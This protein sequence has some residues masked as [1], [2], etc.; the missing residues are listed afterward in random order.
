MIWYLR[1]EDLDYVSLRCHHH[2][3]HKDSY[4]LHAAT[5]CQSG[6][7][8]IEVGHLG[9][10]VGDAFSVIKYTKADKTR[11]KYT[12]LLNLLR[13]PVNAPPFVVGYQ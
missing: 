9:E 6:K 3:V 10:Q 8:R 13:E 5:H 11:N 4:F 7:L 12:H 1:I 2:T